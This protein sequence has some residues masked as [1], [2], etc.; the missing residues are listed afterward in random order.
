MGQ[1]QVPSKGLSVLFLT[2]YVIYNSQGQEQL[3]DSDKHLLRTVLTKPALVDVLRALLSPSSSPS[4]SQP[5]PYPLLHTPSPTPSSSSHLPPVTSFL[6]SGGGGGAEREN[7]LPNEELASPENVTVCL[8]FALT[9]LTVR[10]VYDRE[11]V[12]L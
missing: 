11:S 9:K 4:F 10:D 8:F 1:N 7:P 3:S 5:T 12:C 2:V 6:P